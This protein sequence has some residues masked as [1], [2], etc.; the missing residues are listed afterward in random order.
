LIVADLS[1]GTGHFNFAAGLLLTAVGVGA[2][3]SDLVAGWLAAAFSF[4]A[5]FL[6]LTAVAALAALLYAVGMK[7]TYRSP[8]L[9]PA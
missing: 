9:N 5:A 8:G 6:F 1:Q 2:S 4:R 7:E 3:F